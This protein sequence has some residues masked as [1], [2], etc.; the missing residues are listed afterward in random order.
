MKKIIMYISILLFVVFSLGCVTIAELYPALYG[1]YITFEQ[2]SQPYLN[3]YGIP[4]EVS[5]YNTDGYFSKNWSWY[6]K[7]IIVKFVSSKYS[8]VY[9]WEVYST[10]RFTPR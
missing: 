7:G 3:R 6:S 1:K 4:E 10:Y 5:S 2:V 9:G 8:D